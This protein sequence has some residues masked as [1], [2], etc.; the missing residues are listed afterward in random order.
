MP[1]RTQKPKAE[2]ETAEPKTPKTKTVFYYWLKT[3]HIIETDEKTKKVLEKWAAG[4]YRTTKPVE[5]L[6]A[7]ASKFPNLVEKFE[8]TVPMTRL[9]KIADKFKVQLEN[10]ENNVRTPDELLG[11]IAIEK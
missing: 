9:I 8:G 4:F 1:S 2:G 10:D 7:S 11:E 5:R 6:E 3:P